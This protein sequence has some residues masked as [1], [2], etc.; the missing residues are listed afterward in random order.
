MREEGLRGWEGVGEETVE[1][2][3]RAGT[4]DAVREGLREGEGDD[5]NG[6]G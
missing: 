2:G 6:L 1:E 3:G 4:G 5:E